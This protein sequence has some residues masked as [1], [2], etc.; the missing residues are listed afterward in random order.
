MRISELTLYRADDRD[1]VQETVIL[2]EHMF[3]AML[4]ELE[5]QDSLS[6]HSNVRNLGLI[7]GFYASKASEMRSAG[8]VDMDIDSK[9]K[10]Y[11]GQNFVPY[12]LGYA[13]KYNIVMH[14][15]SDIDEIIAEGEE[16]AEEKD[17]KLPTAK[18]RPLEM[19][20]GFQGIRA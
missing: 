14:G 4:A 8:Y 20:D 7:M 18:K 15:P 10:T 17:V 2:L 12:L 13:R 11:Q 6:A 19:G 5:K 3:L 9:T 1:L 16:E